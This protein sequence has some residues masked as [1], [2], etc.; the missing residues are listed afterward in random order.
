M[1]GWAGE[2]EDMVETSPVY[3]G[4]DVA[5]EHL[6]G[7]VAPAG[8]EWR[9]PH[10]EEGIAQMVARLRAL[11][12]ALV[13][14]EATGGVEVML[15]AALAAADLPVVVV[16]P[17]RVR[18]FARAMGN[19][20]KTDRLDAQ[21]LALFAERVRPPVRPLPDAESQALRALVT[22]R[23]QVVEMLVAE[24]N[25]RR[26]ALPPVR[27]RIERHIT[28]LEQELREMD[29]E[30]SRALRASPL[31]R[32]QEDL[33]R[34]VP[35]IGP[36]LAA[37]LLADLP[38][39]GTLTRHQLAV[40]VGVAPLNRDSGKWRG[41]RTTWGGRAAVRAAL[42]MAALVATRCNPVVQAFYQRVL[43]A[44]KPKKVALTT[45]MRKLLTILNAMVKHGTPWNPD[46]ALTH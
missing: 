23:R 30:L 18:D 4:I 37:T 21:V 3:V 15:V 14:L 12:P 20:A 42:Y 11:R 9:S 5:Q 36:I 26:T 43:A 22:R 45:C 34:S 27:R 1:Q 24:K 2:V 13:V 17:R 39:L 35:G 16:N 19:L 46:Y 8:E 32:E 25:H 28:L 7:A 29:D 44:G 6:D 10:D 40:L 31:W 33:L 38:E 41:K